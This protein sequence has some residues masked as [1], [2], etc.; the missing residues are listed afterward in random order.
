MVKNINDIKLEIISL[1]RNNY[2]NQFHVREMAKL[3]G[4]SHVGLLL[5][6]KK[7][8]K[9]KI[10]L[11]KQVGKSKVYSINFN[12][13]QARDFLSLGEKKKSLELLD[14]EF[15]IKKIYDEFN[16]LNGC[17]IIF[18]SY[19]SGNNTKESDIDLLHI[20]EAKDIDSKKMKEFGKTYGKEIHLI[21]MDL[22][23]FREQLSKQGSLMKE[24]I[25]NHIILYNQDIFINELWR[26]YYGKK[27]S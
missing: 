6:L 23:R 16:N 15:F 18:G 24:V 19:A 21:S 7:F 14:K 4:R 17:L 3:I 1:Y 26:Y 10:L 5:Y 20:G 2:L 13:N 12:N 22:K 8:K 25:K 27:E 11:S 9:D